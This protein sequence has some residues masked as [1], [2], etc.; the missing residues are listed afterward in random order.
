MEKAGKKSSVFVCVKKKPEPNFGFGF[1]APLGNE[2]LNQLTKD[3]A[4]IYTM[5]ELIPLNAA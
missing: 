3:L 5:R 4:D 1:L 2:I